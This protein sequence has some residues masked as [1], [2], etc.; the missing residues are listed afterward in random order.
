MEGPL[1]G[2][3]PAGGPFGVEEGFRE[4]RL[5]S[6]SR[7]SLLSGLG[8]FVLREAFMTVEITALELLHRAYMKCSSTRGMSVLLSA[9]RYL[10]QQK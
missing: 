2:V 1:V 3:L 8:L 5:R 9:M 7:G 6:D 4:G 10:K